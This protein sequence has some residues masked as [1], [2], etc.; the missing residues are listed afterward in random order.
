MGRFKT[1]LRKENRKQS[2]EETSNPQTH[3]RDSLEPSLDDPLACPVIPQVTLC[4]VYRHAHVHRDFGIITEVL[5]I[6]LLPTPDILLLCSGPSLSSLL[7]F[8]PPLNLAER[9][10]LSDPLSR[11]ILPSL[12]TSYPKLY[13][14]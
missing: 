12:F 11:S 13:S 7:A 5:L 4:H 8:F 9:L 2:T 6:I 10:H 1:E 3:Y 14:A